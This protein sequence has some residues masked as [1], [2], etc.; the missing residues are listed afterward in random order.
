MHRPGSCTSCHNPSTFLKK[1]VYMMRNTQYGLALLYLSIK[2]LSG[3]LA[4]FR[5]VIMYLNT[6]RTTK[7][8]MTLGILTYYRTTNNMDS[9]STYR[10]LGIATLVINSVQKAIIH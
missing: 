4:Q 8:I 6:I 7:T 5:V 3:L 1:A 9:T 2:A 10:I